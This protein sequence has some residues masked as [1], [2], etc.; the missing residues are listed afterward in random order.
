[1]IASYVDTEIARQQ[2]LIEVAHELSNRKI[3]ARGG[4]P[5]S[6]KETL[7]A[8]ARKEGG[9]PETPH[10]LTD[11]FASTTSSVVRKALDAGGRVLGVRLPGFAGLLKGKLGPELAAHARIA[12]VGGILHSDELPGY[13][14]TPEDVA[15]VSARL[16]VAAGDAF[17]LVAEAESKGREGLKGVLS[18]AAIATEGVPP[19]T[20][21]PRPD[22]TTTYA[23]PLP[24]RARMYPETDVP[25]IRITK[26]QLDRVEGRLPELPE[27]R[28]ERLLA[29]HRI[30]RQQ[31]A[32]LVEE[33]ADDAFEAIVAEAAE[34]QVVA[35][36][37]TYTFAEVRR[38]G[39]DVDTIPIEALRDLFRR[40]ASGAF[41]KEAIPDLL[42]TMARDRVDV[43]T[44]AR[45]LGLAAMSEAELDEALDAIVAAHEP[46]IRERGERALAPLMGVAMGQL[47]GKA[48][49][50]V[51][52]DKLRSKIA[53]KL[54]AG[55]GR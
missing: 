16:G 22:G 21:E 17:V 37:L 47:R 13:G 40:Y 49:G 2:T 5:V 52:N 41:A 44:A 43:S 50:R 1:M 55:G 28:L 30:P 35:N 6:V 33:G 20:R 24:G 45:S 15:Q 29:S 38:E 26:E 34:P 31:A 42:R 23:R 18:R 4:R 39:L 25:P 54:D 46:M 19:E 36:A 10:D 32:Q 12:G 3:L 9:G 27:V 51:I 53:A 48:D 14:I 11:L 7:L 8:W